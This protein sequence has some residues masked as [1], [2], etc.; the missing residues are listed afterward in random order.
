MHGM[1]HVSEVFAN[2]LRRVG[3]NRPGERRLQ[4]CP[5]LVNR[6]H[7]RPVK[8]MEEHGCGSDHHGRSLR[9]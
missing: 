1:Y 3:P 5:L 6:F 2:V 9:R 7:D 4:N 8:N